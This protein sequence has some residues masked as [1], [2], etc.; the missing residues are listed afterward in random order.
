MVYH[1]DWPPAVGC[2]WLNA[3]QRCGIGTW[4]D[5]H[6]S[7]LIFFVVYAAVFGV[8]YAYMMK[9]IRKGPNKELTNGH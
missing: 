5:P 9:L 8:G 1:G 3:Y 2:I 4:R 6:I 7:L